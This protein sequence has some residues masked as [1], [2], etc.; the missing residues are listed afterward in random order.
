MIIYGLL[1]S[2]K[3]LKNHILFIGEVMFYIECLKNNSNKIYYIYVN[4]SDIEKWIITTKRSYINNYS[5][6]MYIIDS[7]IK[8]PNN[9][10][11][12]IIVGW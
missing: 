3:I 4:P 9:G 10:F 2:I 12:S 6:C 5:D 1:N 7:I 8:N 11:K